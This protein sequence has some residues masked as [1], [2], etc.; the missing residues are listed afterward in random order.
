MFLIFTLLNLKIVMIF[1]QCSL[2]FIST[3][4]HTCWMSLFLLVE[5][6]IILVTCLQNFKLS[7]RYSYFSPCSCQIPV[8]ITKYFRQLAY[9]KKKF[10]S[11]H[12][13][14][15]CS[16]RLSNSLL[17]ASGKGS[18]WWWEHMAEHTAYLM[19]Q[20]IEERQEEGGVPQFPFWGHTSIDL[21]TSHKA[22]PP[23][24]FTSQ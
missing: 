7:L 18:T 1:S 5:F 19:S 23:K 8:I 2:S 6:S 22:L 21:K 11:A 16:S 12:G 3:D 15:G 24:G 9:K 20:E 17:W 10:I 4:K 13:S 14:G